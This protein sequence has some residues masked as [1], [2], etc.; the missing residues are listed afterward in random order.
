LCFQ[1]LGIPE[2]DDRLNTPSMKAYHDT[3]LWHRPAAEFSWDCYLGEGVRGSAGVSPYATPAR[4]EDL[5]GLP[6]AFVNNRC[7]CGQTVA[8]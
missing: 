8:G 5:S 3:P 2:L 6:P 1:Y 4:A 7:G